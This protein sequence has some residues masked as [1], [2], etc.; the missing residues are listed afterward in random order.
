MN[1]VEKCMPFKTVFIVCLLTLAL[2]FHHAALAQ[3]AAASAQQGGL[4]GILGQI[5]PLV[6][7][8]R[9]FLQLGQNPEQP[10]ENLTLNLNDGY[11]ITRQISKE[12][13]EV[14]QGTIEYTDDVLN[15]YLNNGLS[16]QERVNM[17]RRIYQTQQQIA[18]AQQ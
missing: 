15:D 10:I 2:V 6:Q 7:Q 14:L 9:I 3:Q 12:E 1:L 17:T 11:A 18:N 5:T 8:V 13:R 4:A 16:L